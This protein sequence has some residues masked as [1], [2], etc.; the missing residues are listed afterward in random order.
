MPELERIERNTPGTL[1]KQWYEDGVA[2]DPG[3]VT[4]GITRADGTV[5]VAAGTATSGATT[6]PRT[7][8]LGTA[9]TALLDH[10]TVTW[11]STL[12][13]TLLSYVEIVGGFLFSIADALADSEIT[14]TAA[15]IAAARTTAEQAF[16]DVTGVAFVP[17]YARETANGDGT[18]RL[19]VRWPRIRSFRAATV[20]GTALTATEI[21]TVVPQLTGL[22]YPSGWTSGYGN[23]VVGYEHG[24]DYPPQ[25]VSR[26]VLRLAKHYLTDWAADDR[27]MRIDTDAGSYV[28]ATA[29]R[30][31]FDFG[32][33]EVD[34]VAQ[35]Y[36]HYVPLG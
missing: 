28:M 11:T 7:Y 26:A 18:N 21:L 36:S 31:G 27:A 6:N 34:A 3:T 29:G 19:S 23:V 22:Y 25:E 12:K 2:V 10:L 8:N 1:R 14:A 35:R 4:I 16:E 13:G 32:I 24:F 9:Q 15:K 17:R 30:A 33:P 5:L 20:D